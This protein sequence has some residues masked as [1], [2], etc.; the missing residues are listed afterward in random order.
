M[1]HLHLEVKRAIIFKWSCDITWHVDSF[2]WASYC[3]WWVEWPVGHLANYT[4]CLCKDGKGSRVRPAYVQSTNRFSFRYSCNSSMK[5]GLGMYIP[6]IQ[7]TRKIA[8]SRANDVGHNLLSR[9]RIYKLSPFRKIFLGFQKNFPKR[10]SAIQRRV[11]FVLE[12]YHHL[13]EI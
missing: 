10:I 2:E 3:A 6:A 1:W 5:S 12:E 13:V 11:E 9:T 7:S 8:K 4:L